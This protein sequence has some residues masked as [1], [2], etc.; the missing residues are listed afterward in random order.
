MQFVRVQGVINHGQLHGIEHKSS[1]RRQAPDTV[2]MLA[3]AKGLLRQR[4]GEQA[5]DPFDES[6]AI[7]RLPGAENVEAIARLAA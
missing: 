1:R 7:A 6:L 4:A 2:T 5:V 3:P